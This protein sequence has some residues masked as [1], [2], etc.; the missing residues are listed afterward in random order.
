[1]HDNLVSGVQQTL[2]TAGPSGH[3]AVPVVEP[4]SGTVDGSIRGQASNHNDNKVQQEIE[5]LAEYYDETGHFLTM[6]T[7]QTSIPGADTDADFKSFYRQIKA[8]AWTWVQDYFSD[9]DPE[10]KISL[11]LLHLAYTAPQLM[12]YTNWISCCGP[13]C[14]WEDVFNEQ[15]AQLVYGILGKMLE[16]HV[17]GH[18]MFGADKDQLR[19]LK[20]LDMEL[21]N[22]DGNTFFCFPSALHL[23]GTPRLT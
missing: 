23:R 4:V 12:E 5:S 15:R 8:L 6:T 14:T 22:R 2:E 13:K 11:D 19:D 10:A 18:E 3:N 20:E 1:M 21:V 17:F 16:V 9:V 7:T